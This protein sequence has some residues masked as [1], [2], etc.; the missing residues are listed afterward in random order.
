MNC[1]RS[2]KPCGMLLFGTPN[3]NA[4]AGNRSK[5]R[6]PTYDGA[7][8]PQLPLELQNIVL[9]HHGANKYNRQF[10]TGDLED[11]S[12]KSLAMLFRL[13]SATPPS[14]R[15][16]LRLIPEVFMSDK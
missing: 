9:S 1:T 3:A 7:V 10:K 16:V 12:E 11:F 5:S 15:T 4:L 13:G 2:L 6:T 8:F 14:G